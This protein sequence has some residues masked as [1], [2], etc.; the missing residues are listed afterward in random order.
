MLKLLKVSKDE[1]EKG[2]CHTREKGELVQKLFIKDADLV[3][4]KNVFFIIECQKYDKLVYIRRDT[5]VTQVVGSNNSRYELKCNAININEMCKHLDRSIEPK[6]LEELISANLTILFSRA[7]CDTAKNI[8]KNYYE[9]ILMYLG[10]K[11]TDFVE[12]SKID[13]FFSNY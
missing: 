13:N 9:R 10:K 2:I 3:Y 6:K 8:W 12:Q 11:V 1:A 5:K 7:E 4:D